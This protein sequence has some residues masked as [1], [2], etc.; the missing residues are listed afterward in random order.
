MISCSALVEKG[1]IR[2]LDVLLF[3]QLTLKP[4][5]SQI[6]ITGSRLELAHCFT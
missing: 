4:A 1:K 6:V 3:Q 5:D 2:S